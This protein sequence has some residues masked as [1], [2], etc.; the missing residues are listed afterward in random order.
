MNTLES[1]YDLTIPLVEYQGGPYSMK[2][3]QFWK[4]AGEGGICK[5][6]GTILEMYWGGVECPKCEREYKKHLGCKCN[7]TGV[8]PDCINAGILDDENK[9]CEDVCSTLCPVCNP[10]D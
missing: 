1:K 8:C 5:R 10:D 6:C 4:E 9:R 2:L 3:L 7:G